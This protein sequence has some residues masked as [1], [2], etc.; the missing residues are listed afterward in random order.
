MKKTD[1]L[2]FA[3]LFILEDGKPIQV[4]DWQHDNIIEPVFYTLD[5]NGLR[6]YNLSL[7]GMPKKNGKSTLSSLVACY[8]LL[9][10][11]ENEP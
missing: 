9:A 10:D 8:M 3:K 2:T 5:D 6:R 4:E 1:I 7:S 11:G